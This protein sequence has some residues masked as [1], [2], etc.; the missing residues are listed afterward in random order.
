MQRVTRE[1]CKYLTVLNTILLVFFVLTGPPAMAYIMGT[2]TLA[3]YLSMK[4]FDKI[5][6]E[7]NKRTTVMHN[8]GSNDIEEWKTV[9]PERM[10]E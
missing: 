8:D 2:A 5:I 6:G 3:T 1:L 4:L 10:Q 9:E 7:S